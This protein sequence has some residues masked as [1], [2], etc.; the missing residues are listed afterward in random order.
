MLYL[1]DIDGT[2]VDTGG[3]GMAALEQATR[4]IFGQP[5]PP[6]DLAGATDLGIVIGIHEHFSI[7]AT[8]ERIAAYL[9]IYQQRLDW[10]LAHGGHPGRVLDGVSSLLEELADRPHATLGLLTGNTAGGAASKVR[11]FGL[12][13]YFPFGAYGCDDP[14]RKRLGPIALARAAAHAGRPFS[15]AETWVIGDTPKD[16]ACARAIGARCLAVATG[17]FDAGQLEA[18]GADRVVESLEQAADWI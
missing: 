18:H 13:A 15:A 12:S 7:E 16:I 2:L 11:H 3:A 5:G 6:L 4:E 8:P 10:N 14:D 9:A 1:F 17:R